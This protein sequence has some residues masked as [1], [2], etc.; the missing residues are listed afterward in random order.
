MDIVQD[1]LVTGSTD[2]TIRV[3]DI[4]T[5]KCLHVFGGYLGTVRALSI[6]KPQI[7][8]IERDGI[9]MKEK[10]PKRPL[11]VT[12]SRDRSLRVWNLPG[13]G[14]AEFKCF[15]DGQQVDSRGLYPDVVSRIVN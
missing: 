5:G 12:G 10:C 9:V 13:P 1:I 14:D 3:W 2:R 4:S 11:I 7:M 15:S 6:A 8:E